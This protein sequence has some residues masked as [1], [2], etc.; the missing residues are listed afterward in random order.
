MNYFDWAVVGLIDTLTASPYEMIPLEQLLDNESDLIIESLTHSPES[1]TTEDV[2]VFVCTVKNVGDSSAESST[3]EF[4]IGGEGPSS[5]SNWQ[6]YWFAVPS[7][8]IGESFAISRSAQLRAQRYGNTAI[9]DIF[10]VVVESDETN[11]IKRDSYTVS[12]P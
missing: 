5:S 6:H 1:P 10:N 9:A 12:I 8:D 4:R 11:N 3:V 2:I 7:L